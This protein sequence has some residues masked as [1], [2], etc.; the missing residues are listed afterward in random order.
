M[1]AYYIHNGKQQ[2]GPFTYEELKLKGIDSNTSIWFEG[3]ETWIDA[4]NLD[5]LKEIITKAPPPFTKKHTTPPP[6]EKAKKILNKDYIDEIEKKIPSK[7]GKKAFKIILIITAV[8]GT[9]FLI[10]KLLPMSGIIESKSATDYLI[11]TN[12]RGDVMVN[13][14]DEEIG[15]TRIAGELKN[16]S[17]KTKY[18]DFKIEIQ[19]YSSTKSII[20]TK[21]IVLFKEIRPMDTKEIYYDFKGKVPRDAYYIDWKIIDATAVDVE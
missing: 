1:K 6:F 17:E 16:N 10:E 13:N 2:L 21:E 5:E 14:Y 8:I 15:T 18:K 11:L 9:L 12:I 4:G 20:S 19:Y 7:K 3:L